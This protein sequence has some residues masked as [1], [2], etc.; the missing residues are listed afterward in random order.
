MNLTR[1]LERT[2][3]RCPEISGED[4]STFP[5]VS[6]QV[7]LLMKSEFSADSSNIYIFP[8]VRSKEASKLFVEIYIWDLVNYPD[9]CK[10]FVI[11][12]GCRMSE[13]DEEK[14][15]DYAKRELY[16]F[17][18]IIERF[19]IEVQIL[20]PQ[21][22]FPNYMP[23]Q[24][25][26]MMEHLYFTSHSSGPREILYKAELANI[27]YHVN[28][29][30]TYNIIGST[31]EKIMG[32]GLSLK[33]L[34]ILNQWE[35]IDFLF[36]TEKLDSCR[37]IY[38]KYSGFIGKNPVTIGQWKYLEELTNPDG[39]FYGMKFN[40]TIYKYLRED[41]SERILKEYRQFLEFR[42]E[43]SEAKKMKIPEPEDLHGVVY[44]LKRIKKYQKD[45]TNIDTLFKFRKE[46]NTFEYRGPEYSV[47]MPRS[48]FDIC[49]EAISQGNCVMDYIEAH[50]SGYTTILFIRKNDAINQSFVT[51]EI[52]N[53][54]WIR[55][56]YGKFNSLPEKDIYL[57]LE[58]YAQKAWLFYDPAELITER[59]DEI[60]ECAGD[61]LNN[62]L[63][64]YRN[65]HSSRTF[66][67]ENEKVEYIQLSMDDLYPGIF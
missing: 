49:L 6:D 13:E 9:V 10:R 22:H 54:R 39:L 24:I 2:F 56:V 58:E 1:R 11:F 50:A 48:S 5:A 55:A 64:D 40:R 20:F 38:R 60:F 29:L 19:C 12:E 52:N 32:S 63:E 57:F 61:E 53:D 62:Y 26:E 21:W 27:A 51:M 15:L 8:F 67:F 16:A 34:R 66:K 17:T 14:Y 37:E 23:D 36:E 45:N 41:Y 35:F 59:F 42:L 65:R 46:N 44:K 25:G 3:F 28:Q 18:E 47:V 43:F 7:F 31:P 30:P 33:L 4:Y